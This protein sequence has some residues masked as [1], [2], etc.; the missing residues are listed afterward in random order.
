MVSFVSMGLFLPFE[1]EISVAACDAGRA[2]A[3]AEF[4]AL[5]SRWS[6]H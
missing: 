3:R 1:V 5:R 2:A 6:S 4:V